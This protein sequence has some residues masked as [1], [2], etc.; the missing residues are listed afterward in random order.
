MWVVIVVGSV[1]PTWPL[2][3][4]PVR[5]LR[6]VTKSQRNTGSG[7][8]WSALGSRARRRYIFFGGNKPTSMEDYGNAIELRSAPHDRKNLASSSKWKHIRLDSPREECG[9]WDEDDSLPSK[10]VVT[11]SA[12]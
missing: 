1:P 11:T 8:I 7:G 5:R 4:R 3:N 2:I 10:A 9:G 12:V 6:E